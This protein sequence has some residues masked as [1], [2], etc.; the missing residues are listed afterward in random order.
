MCVSARP[1]RYEQVGQ[2]LCEEWSVW[3]DVLLR[4]SDP[5]T[6]RTLWEGEASSGGVP[7]HRPASSSPPG[8]AR[9]PIRT[10][11]KLPSPTPL[12]SQRPQGNLEKDTNTVSLSPK[13]SVPWWRGWPA[14]LLRPK[15]VRLMTPLSQTLAQRLLMLNNIN[16]L[17][18]GQS[19]W[20]GRSSLVGVS[21]DLIVNHHTVHQTLGQ[22]ARVL[23]AQL[24]RAQAAQVLALKSHV[25]T[26]RAKFC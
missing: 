5:S 3:G 22:Q 15:V 10:L 26:V 7:V 8:D 11:S 6:V 19:C 25:W 16:V 18:S 20:S 21:G 4:P 1:T 17:R 9:C 14:L 24:Q 2:L 23:L 12:P 13:N